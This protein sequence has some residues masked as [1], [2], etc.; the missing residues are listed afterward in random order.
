MYRLLVMVW[1]FFG[2]SLPASAGAWFRDEGGGFLSFGSTLFELEATGEQFQE[3]SLFA[4]FGLRGDLTI[5]TSASII[6][7]L[8]GEGQ[9]FLRLP[10]KS[11]ESD[12]QLAAE[13][14]LGATSDG[15]N[16]D[17]FV[18]TGLSWGRGITVQDRNGWI[19]VDGNAFIGVDG[20]GNRI[21]IDTTLGLT[22]TNHAQI[23]G[24]SFAELTPGADSHTILP[25][26]VLKPAKGR[27]SYVVGYEHR[28]GARASRGIKFG[29]WH[30]F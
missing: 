16:T 10:I 29:L 7:G 17:P 27:T 5:G 21:K 19:N 20:G 6:D 18:K 3:Q 14:G 1:L 12:S 23:I 15:I 26:L 13:F 22:L 4:E 28:T 2:F 30:D 24:Q 9:V 11:P 25:S 8:G